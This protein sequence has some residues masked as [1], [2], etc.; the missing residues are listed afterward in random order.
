MQ[1]EE[2]VRANQPTQDKNYRQTSDQ[3]EVPSQEKSYPRETTGNVNVKM[4]KETAVKSAMCT[5]IKSYSGP[6][7]KEND[8]ADVGMTPTN[9]N[10]GSKGSVDTGTSR[11]DDKKNASDQTCKEGNL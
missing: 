8:G 9:D 3:Q 6:A 1:D 4:N 5:E 2:Q 10:H 7:H 11:N